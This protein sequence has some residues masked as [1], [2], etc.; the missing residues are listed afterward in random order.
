[1]LTRIAIC[2]LPLMACGGDAA[3]TPDG[4]NV[5]AMVIVSGVVSEITAQGRVPTAG[6]SLSAFKEGGTTALATG[7]SDASG[8]FSLSIP[9]G[10]VALDGYV[11]AHIPNYMDTYLYPPAPLTADRTV[12]VFILKPATFGAAGAL[13]QVSQTAGKAW[14][15]VQA[16]D[17]SDMTVGGVVVTS[18]PA[19]TVRYNGANGLPT[20]AAG[21]TMTQMDG[22]AYIFN[23][24][25]GTVSVSAAKSGATFHTHNVNA[26]A[27][28]ITLTLI[29]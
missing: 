3:P 20:N 18:T 21:A 7:T 10:G 1:M 9:T 6:V 25:P 2:L 13:A 12:P 16:I 14:I 22:I 5:P 17:A 8:N 19:G 29:Q 15:G 24:T 11:L 26:R 4:S 27:D 23:A 28:Q